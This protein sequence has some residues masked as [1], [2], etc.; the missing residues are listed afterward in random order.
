[1]C[2]YRSLIS[3]VGTH[4]LLVSAI[5]YLLLIWAASGVFLNFLIDSEISFSLKE[6]HV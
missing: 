2:M 4:V 6:G 1:M 3:K 5:C